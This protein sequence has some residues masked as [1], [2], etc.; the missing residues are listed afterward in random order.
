MNFLR[1]R[2]PLPAV[3]MVAALSCLPCAIAQTNPGIL[4]PEQAVH[5]RTLPN[6]IE[7]TAHGTVLQVTALRDDVL[8][9]RA[10]QNAHL[11]EDASWAVISTA[12][13]ASVQ[14]VPET[15]GDSMGFHTAT[16]RVR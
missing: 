6:G 10:G 7:I 8:R 16:L 4:Q 15:S 13:T 12:R 2:V 14:T 5:A 3:L 9:V 11:P 1:P